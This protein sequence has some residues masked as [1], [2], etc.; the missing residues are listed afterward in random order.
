MA[1]LSIIDRIE[2]I[3]VKSLPIESLSEVED[4]NL[5]ELELDSLDFLELIF[6]VNEEFGTSI[7]VDDFSDPTQT[8]GALISKLE[9]RIRKESDL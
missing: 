4:K 6:E 2:K 1:K 9:N 7:P 3:A 5:D 8:M